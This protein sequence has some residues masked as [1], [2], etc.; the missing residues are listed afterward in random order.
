MVLADKI[1]FLAGPLDVFADQTSASSVDLKTAIET[2][3][4]KKD[5]IL[6]AVSAEDGKKLAEYDLESLPV[7]DGLI[8]ANR[9]LYISMKNGRVLCFREK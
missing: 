1:I 9:R 5:A 2:F 4:G 3:E 8:A 6:Y 7:Y